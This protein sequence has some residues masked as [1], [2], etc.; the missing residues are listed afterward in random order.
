[1]ACVYAYTTSKLKTKRK[2]DVV[3]LYADATTIPTGALDTNAFTE[4]RFDFIDYLW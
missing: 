3:A 4:A 2:V 1:M